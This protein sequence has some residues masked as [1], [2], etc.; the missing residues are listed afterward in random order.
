MYYT[1]IVMSTKGSHI[2]KTMMS[3]SSKTP[4]PAAIPAIAAV[5]ST[6]ERKINERESG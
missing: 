3:R 1:S 2:K 4:P 5:L 6:R